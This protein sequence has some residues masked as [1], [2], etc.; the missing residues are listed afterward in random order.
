MK[1]VENAK[2]HCGMVDNDPKL[3]AIVLLAA[4]VK[5]T[6]DFHC[7]PNIHGKV[8]YYQ[9]GDCIASWLSFLIFR[10]ITAPSKT[11]N[12]HWSLYQDLQKLKYI[13]KGISSSLIHL[14]HVFSL[15]NSP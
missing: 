10:R 12:Y 15:I 8:G 5:S 7:L 14:I 9:K 11:L 13:L 2:W 3:F 1:P 4:F 6:F